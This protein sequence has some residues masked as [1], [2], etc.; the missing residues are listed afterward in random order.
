MQV[1]PWKTPGF[2]IPGDGS[3]RRAEP[4]DRESLPF[5]SSGHRSKERRVAFRHG[6]SRPKSKGVR[7]GKFAPAPPKGAHGDRP[8]THFVLRE[9]SPARKTAELSARTSSNGFFCPRNRIYHGF[10]FSTSQP[11][12]T[13]P[14]SLPSSSGL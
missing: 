8:S 1:G 10:S 13:K 9:P 11:L 14:F 12:S 3:A 7:T 6:R 2:Q 5:P 4:N